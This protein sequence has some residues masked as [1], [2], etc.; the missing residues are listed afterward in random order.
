[1]K[2]R[3]GLNHLDFSLW[4]KPV[5]STDTQ[6]GKDLDKWMMLMPLRAVVGTSGLSFSCV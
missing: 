4:K 1:V 5:G 3:A 2:E 6:S